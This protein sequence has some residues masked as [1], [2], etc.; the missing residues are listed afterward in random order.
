MEKDCIST[1]NVSDPLSP[2]PEWRQI[3]E[4][5][6]QEIVDGLLEKYPYGVRKV[7][8]KDN[9]DLAVF[10]C[11]LL[12]TNKETRPFYKLYQEQI[13]GFRGSPESMFLQHNGRTCFVF[14]KNGMTT[15]IRKDQDISYL[16]L[17]DDEVKEIITQIQKEI[18][19]RGN[20]F[21][22]IEVETEKYLTRTYY[23]GLFDKQLS[24]EFINSALGTMLRAINN[25]AEEEKREKEFPKEVD[26][27][28]QKDPREEMVKKMLKNI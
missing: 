20:Y 7:T 16:E 26:D 1:S 5:N 3:E 11:R 23:K 12:Y 14:S 15:I 9:S 2:I 8:L 19:S 13:P 24:R 18:N 6:N 21:S 22:S 27:I 25:L 10:D 17:N 4:L 28:I